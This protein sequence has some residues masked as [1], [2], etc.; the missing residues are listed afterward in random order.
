MGT[1]IPNHCLHTGDIDDPSSISP[2]HLLNVIFAALKHTSRIHSHG[3]VVDACHIFAPDFPPST[4]VSVVKHDCFDWPEIGPISLSTFYNS[5]FELP[6][7]GQNLRSRQL[8]TRC[9]R[10]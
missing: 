9:R 5:K 6:F 2:K 4:V 8:Y 10:V 1:P 3:L 7:Q